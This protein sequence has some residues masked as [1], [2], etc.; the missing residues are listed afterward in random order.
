MTLKW[1]LIIVIF[2]LKS[3]FH[4]YNL[5]AY[6]RKIWRTRFAYLTKI[7]QYPYDNMILKCF[8]LTIALTVSARYLPISKH[9]FKVIKT[10]ISKIINTN[11]FSHVKLISLLCG[12]LIYIFMILGK[13][14]LGGPFLTLFIRFFF[15]SDDG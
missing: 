8:L 7:S 6:H 4:C 15:I 12:G 5:F 14:F 9:F 11:I 3:W 2:T 13:Y 10:I 1:Y